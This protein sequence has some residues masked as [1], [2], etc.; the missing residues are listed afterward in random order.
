MQ[1]VPL[2][3]AIAVISSL[4]LLWW[5]V[6][7]ART[8]TTATKN[9]GVWGADGLDRRSTLRP[10]SGAAG[11][12]D[13]RQAVLSHSVQERAVGPA[14]ERMAER[15][16]RLTP[17]GMMENLERRVLLAGVPE[18]WP[19]EKVLAAKLGLGAVATVLGGLLFIQAPSFGRLLMVLGAIAL[20]W[21]LPDL[22]L[23]NTA[24]K[25]QLMIQ[26]A[27]PDL[28]DQMT[29]AVEAGLAFDGAMARAAAQVKAH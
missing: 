16:R 29:I 17:T 7:G 21:F 2:L 8:S 3:G 25:R 13:L 18:A 11:F 28:L 19:M 23:Y 6:S 9:L 4:P 15:A 14:V 22:L 26:Q 12:T 27:L 20:G 1:L 24:T 5:A 10:G